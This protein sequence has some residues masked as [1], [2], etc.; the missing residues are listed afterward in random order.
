MGYFFLYFASSWAPF[1]Q[2][3]PCLSGKAYICKRILRISPIGSTKAKAHCRL[4]CLSTALLHIVKSKIACTQH[5][6]SS[7][8]LSTNAVSKEAGRDEEWEE[9]AKGDEFHS[10][11]AGCHGWQPSQPSHLWT[12]LWMCL[13]FCAT[14][15]NEEN[16]KHVS[17]WCVRVKKTAG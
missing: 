5:S 12:H 16:M 2:K 3:S 1:I 17:G 13:W 15:K 6:H 8:C 9:T 11:D 14:K 4:T 10:T 7:G